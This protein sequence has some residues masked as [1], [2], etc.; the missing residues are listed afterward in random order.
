VGTSKSFSSPPLYCQFLSVR[1]V[2]DQAPKVSTIGGLFPSPFSK[3]LV[4]LYEPISSCAACSPAATTIHHEPVMHD[5][6]G[7]LSP[8]VTFFSRQEQ[9]VHSAT[10]LIINRTPPTFHPP[11]ASPGGEPRDRFSFTGTLEAGVGKTPLRT[12]LNVKLERF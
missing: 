7:L 10:W 11:P 2:H 3:P 9:I 1:F 8:L 4:Y 6:L 12:P 5:F